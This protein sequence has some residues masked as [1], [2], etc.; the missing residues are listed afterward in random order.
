L[1]ACPVLIAS[2][3]GRQ[4]CSAVVTF[5]ANQTIFL[6]SIGV[7][8]LASSLTRIGVSRPSPVCSRCFTLIS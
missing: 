4:S 8:V 3:L 5:N 6:S 7:F 2:L 1:V